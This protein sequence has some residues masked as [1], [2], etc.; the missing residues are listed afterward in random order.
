MQTCAFVVSAGS[1]IQTSFHGSSVLNTTFRTVASVVP[2][3]SA[4]RLHASIDGDVSQNQGVLTDSA[5]QTK[6]KSE[7]HLEVPCSDCE[8]SV[9]QI[10]DN[11]PEGILQRQKNRELARKNFKLFMNEFNGEFDN[12][13][14]VVVN[15]KLGLYPREGGGHEHIHCQL[16]TVRNDDEFGVILAKYYFDGNPNIVF[17]VRLYEVNLVD[18][19]DKGLLEM[20]IYRFYDETEV[21]LREVGYR[22][23]KIEWMREDMY[24]WLAGCE[25]LWEMRPA[26]MEESKLT[27]NKVNAL[28]L[29]PQ[30]MKASEFS[31]LGYMA[32]GGCTVFS[33]KV[34]GTI[35]ILDDLFCGGNELWVNDRGF[36]KDGGYIYG[37]QRGVPYKMKRVNE[38]NAHLIWTL[39]GGGRPEAQ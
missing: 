7:Q 28:T 38:K 26:S 2:K 18:T 31:F 23:D 8:P 20:K 34:K 33:P 17:R 10:L 29:D 39:G 32:Q 9:P 24:E 27:E 11:S 4:A 35:K 22:A 14:Q 6:Y 12:Y 36:N 37:N 1:A 3:R 15:K 19:S 16:Q 13:D 25:V 5:L 30:V 21:R